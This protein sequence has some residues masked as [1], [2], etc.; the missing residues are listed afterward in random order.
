MKHLTLN[1]FRIINVS[2]WLGY[3]VLAANFLSPEWAGQPA[4]KAGV[5]AMAQW[6]PMLDSIRALPGVNDWIHTFYAGVWLLAP[7][8]VLSGWY[9]RQQ[10][11]REKKE[12][13]RTCSDWMLLFNVLIFYPLGVWIVLYWP[14]P[15]VNGWRDRSVGSG[16]FGISYTVFIMC[17]YFF[18]W[19]AVARMIYARLR[20][21]H[22]N[23]YVAQSQQLNPTE[24]SDL[25]E[26][27]R[28]R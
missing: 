24:T 21:G 28:G 17:G 20:F 10:E 23:E 5:A 19:G 3:L 27:T 1:Q 4:V 6:I 16:V 14:I 7:F 9:M 11:C 8:Y 22:M 25:R 13:A 12:L 15:D 2:V 18:A 26:I